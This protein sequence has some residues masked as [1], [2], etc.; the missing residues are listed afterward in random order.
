MSN[1]HAPVYILYILGTFFDDGGREIPAFSYPI[2]MRFRFKYVEDA[3][4]NSMDE[5]IQKLIKLIRDYNTRN[6]LWTSQV[7]ASLVL[8]SHQ[9]AAETI[10]DEVFLT[11]DEIYQRG[12]WLEIKPPSPNLLPNILQEYVTPRRGWAIMDLKTDNNSI[13]V[14]TF[15]GQ[16]ITVRTLI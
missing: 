3:I 8:I 5:E 11:V 12:G 9:D 6:R 14:H 1:Y 7:S 13:T 4:I 10:E 2:Q 15:G 16:T